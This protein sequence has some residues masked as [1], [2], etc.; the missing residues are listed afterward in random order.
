MKPKVSL[1]CIQELATCSYREPD[2][3][4]LLRGKQKEI[5]TVWL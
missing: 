4:I 1:L 5:R 3:S 2:H